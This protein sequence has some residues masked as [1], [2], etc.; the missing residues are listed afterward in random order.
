MLKCLRVTLRVFVELRYLLPEPQGL[1]WPESPQLLMATVLLCTAERCWMRKVRVGFEKGYILVHQNLSLTTD[2]RL[3]STWP[4]IPS[5]SSS[6]SP[7]HWVTV[8]FLLLCKQAKL[9]PASGPW[10]LLSPLSVWHVQL[11]APRMC[12]PAENRMAY[13][14]PCLWPLLLIHTLPHTH[15]LKGILFHILASLA[16]SLHSPLWSVVSSSGGLS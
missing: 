7:G 5:L 13:N 12:Q 14:P 9:L 6:C 3:P 10:H 4:F 1:P 11:S 16:L 15:P 8:T 2:N